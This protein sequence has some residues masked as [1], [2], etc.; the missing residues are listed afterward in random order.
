M[1]VLKNW[2]V[3]G[4]WPGVGWLTSYSEVA[5][6]AASQRAG[7]NGS[8]VKIWVPMYV[9]Y[10]PLQALGALMAQLPRGVGC[11]HPEHGSSVLFT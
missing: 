11:V 5:S 2:Q 9:L 7:S 4:I 10:V 1:K 8:P 6:Q 3:I